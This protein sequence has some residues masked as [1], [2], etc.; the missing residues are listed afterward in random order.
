M[1]D[2]GIV[3][4]R[5][6]KEQGTL[7]AEF[8]STRYEDKKICKGYAKGNVSEGISGDYVITY[9][10]SNGET[11]GTFDLNI[12]QSH[13]LYDLTWRESGVVKFRG[14]GM[15]IHG[16]IAAGWRMADEK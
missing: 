3:I 1:L 10:D 15:D 13:Q 8:Y 2:I 16:G 5:P 6:G 7:E 9:Y 11:T 4:Y 14:I 12:T